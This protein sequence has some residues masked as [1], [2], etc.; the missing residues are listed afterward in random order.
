MS[1]ARTERRTPRIAAEFCPRSRTCSCTTSP[2]L[3]DGRTSDIVTAIKAHGG[4]ATRVVN[5]FNG[6]STAPDAGSNLSV[7]ESQNLVYFLR[8]LL[9]GCT[10]RRSNPTGASRPRLRNNVDVIEEEA[11]ALLGGQ[12]IG[13]TEAATWADL[14]C[15]GGTFT[16]A[17]AALLPAGSVIHAMDR[18]AS[19]LRHIPREHAG[20]SIVTHVGDFASPPW[21]FSALDGVLLANSLHYVRDQLAFIR[22]C[23]P[24]MNHPHSF[25]IVEY[26]TDSANRWVP[27]PLSRTTLGRL[28]SDAGLSSIAFLGSQPSRYQRSEM[29]AARI[30]SV[31]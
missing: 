18:N 19:A 29:Y 26:D 14:G 17:L 5:N 25:L 16:L 28:S 22:A 8:S 4:E 13:G 24:V 27:Y 11:I 7:A 12:R 1:A 30:C 15:G 6:V 3:H 2:A 10:M 20:I 21:P 31:P 23:A 9:A